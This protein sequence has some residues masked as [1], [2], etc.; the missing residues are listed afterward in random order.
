MHFLRLCMCLHRSGQRKYQIDEKLPSGNNIELVGRNDIISRYIFMK[1]D[2]Y[3]ARKQVSSH[4]Q[5]WAHCK[6]PPSNRDMSMDTFQELQQ[7]FR[8]YYSRPTTDFAQPK[9]KIRRVVSAS[10]VPASTRLTASD[11]LGI[12]DHGS[13]RPSDIPPTRKHALPGSEPAAK[14]CKRVLSGVLE[15]ITLVAL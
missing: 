3:R 12:F 6:K 1:T 11:A 4:I 9:K 14:R 13:P 8:L 15:P 5:V 2:K 10:S 7:I